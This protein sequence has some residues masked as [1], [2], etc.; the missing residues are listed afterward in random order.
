[1]KQQIGTKT[2]TQNNKHVF[3]R[4]YLLLNTLR[5]EKEGPYVRGGESYIKTK[6]RSSAERSRPLRGPKL[7]L[8]KEHAGS[9]EDVA[10]GR[11]QAMDCLFPR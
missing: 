3:T 11:L 1:M 4:L 5:K 6:R 9:G 7:N 8:I 2:R 10:P